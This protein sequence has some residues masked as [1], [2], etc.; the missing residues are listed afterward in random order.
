[1]PN[2]LVSQLFLPF[3]APLADLVTIMGILFGNGFTVLYYYL[4]FSDGRDDN[5]SHSIFI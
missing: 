3:I 4:L 1:M 5:C 2:I